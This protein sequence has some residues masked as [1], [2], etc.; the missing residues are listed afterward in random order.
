MMDMIAAYRAAVPPEQFGADEARRFISYVGAQQLPVPH[1]AEILDFEDALN[2][3]TGALYQRRVAFDCNPA[4]LFDALLQ[5]QS[6]TGLAHERCYVDVSSTG[7][8]ILG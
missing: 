8:Q 5:R 4:A 1:L 3:A 7:I 6:P 2:A